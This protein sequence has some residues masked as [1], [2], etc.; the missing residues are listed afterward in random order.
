LSGVPSNLLDAKASIEA[1]LE[2]RA[3]SGQGV[4][5]AAMHEGDGNIQG[6]AVGL[7]DET[8][9]TGEPGAPSLVVYVAEHTTHD[10]VRSV[11]SNA[12]G[13]SAG[14]LDEVP[15]HVVRTGV[16]DAHS[17]RFRIRPTPGGMSV[18]HYK[19]TAGTI[20]CLTRGRTAPRNS[21]LM[22]L[23]NNHVLANVNAGVYGDCVTQP[24]PYDGGT[25]PA[26]QVA[27]LE[28]FVPLNLSGGANYVDCATGWAWPD[29]V[30]VEL[31]YIAS[32]GGLAYFRVSN[33]PIDPAAGMYV[34]K[35]GR[36]TQ[37]RQGRISAIGATV[38]VNYGGGRVG[39]F[40][41]QFAVQGTNGDFS[42]GGDSGSLIW[43]WDATRNP[44][45]LLFAGGGGTTFANPIKYVL[46]ALDVN[47]WT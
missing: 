21:R 5:A 28:R 44:V 9:V 27:I 37:L 42:Q 25:C 33:V 3:G 1:I 6:V 13:V 23:S 30:R 10:A 17:H 43:R 4:Q 36:T 18:G 31:A 35:T 22:I 40:K 47:L 14:A 39:L 46:N 15:V 38:N 29:R 19:I 11:V 16:I 26:D 32:G 24:G 7:G 34:G 12:A 41:N 2:L 8:S 20:G 45:G